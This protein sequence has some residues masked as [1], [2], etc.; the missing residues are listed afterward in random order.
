MSLPKIEKIWINHIQDRMELRVDWS[1]DRHHSAQILP[2]YGVEEVS[3]AL[4]VMSVEIRH[5]LALREAEQDKLQ[6]L[7]DGSLK[8]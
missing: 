6:Y 5:D 1:N 4:Q 8:L 3:R 7:S 2:P